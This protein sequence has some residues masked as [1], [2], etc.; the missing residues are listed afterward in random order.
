[1]KKYGR[2]LL[3]ATGGLGIILL[4]LVLLLTVVAPRVISSASVKARIRTEFSRAVGGTLDFDRLGVSLF[5][6]PGVVVYGA[7]LAI[8]EKGSGTVE[9]V[10]ACPQLLPLLRGKV[11]IGK[12]RIEQPV[13]RLDLSAFPPLGDGAA[14]SPSRSL[15]KRAASLFGVL[16]SKVPDL[17]IEVSRGGLEL[18]DNGRAILNIRDLEAKAAFPPRG[19]DVQVSCRSNLWQD[20]SLEGRLDARG[21]KGGG[22]IELSGFQPH[23]L[24]DRL[25]SKAGITCSESSVSLRADIRTEGL[26]RFHGEIKASIPRMILSRNKEESVFKAVNAGATFS[27]EGDKASVSLDQL[28]LDEP[29]LSM[30]GAF[31][32]DRSAS[33]VRL[34]LEARDMDVGAVRHAALCL[35]GESRVVRDIFDYVRGGVIPVITFRSRAPT[36]HGLGVDEAFRIDGVIRDGKIHIRGPGL[37]PDQ[38]SGKAVIEKGILEGEDL[39]ARLGNSRAHDGR[40]RVGLKKGDTAPF[41]LEIMVDAD[42]AEVRP[43]LMRV[44]KPGTFVRELALVDSLQGCAQGKLTLGEDLHAMVAKVDVSQCR[45]SAE[46]RRIPLPVRIDAGEV[47]YDPDSITCRNLSGSLGESSFSG[48]AVRVGFGNDPRIRIESGRFHLLMDEI[49]PWL[50]SYESLRKDLELFRDVKGRIDLTA[51]RLDGPVLRAAEWDF[52]TEAAVQ[53]LTVATRLCPEPV[54]IASGRLKADPKE[55]AFNDVKARLLD[56]PVV[57]SGV[58]YGY[59]KGLGK[60]ETTLEGTIGSKSFDW[61]ADIIHLPDGLKVRTPVPLSQARLVWNRQGNTSFRGDLMFPGGTKGSIDLVQDPHS[62]LLK[63]LSIRDEQSRATLAVTR[64]GDVLGLKFTGNLTA[65]TMDKVFLAN[66]APDLSMKGDFL[67]NIRLD[68]P[69]F[70]EAYGHL[71]ARDFTIP[72]SWMAPIRIDSLS[73]DA[74][75]HGIRV[76]P[77]RFTLEQSRLSLKGE[78][79][80]APQGIHVD[81]DLASA[82]IVWDTIERVIDRAKPEE[83]TGEEAFSSWPRMEGTVRCRTESFTY[84]AFTWAPLCASVTFTP[85]TLSVAVTEADL[86]GI[87]TLGAL[88]RH[89]D[90]IHVDLQLIAKDRDLAPALPCLSDT[91]RQVTGRFDLTGTIKGEGKADAF[92][93]A[94][95]GHMEL[96]ARDGNILKDPL[97]AKV[98][99][100]LNVTEILRGKVPDLS[101][102]E[103]PYDSFT[104]TG[105]LQEGKLVLSEI[106]LSG[107]TVGIVGD[108]TLDLADTMVDMKLVVAPLRTVDFIVEKTPVVK[109]IMG[110]KV[111]TVPV[112][113][114]GDWAD[115][116]VS[117][118][119]ASA[120]GT[121]LLGIMKNTLMLPVDLMQ[122]V[123][124]KNGKNNKK[125]P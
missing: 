24:A 65:E 31:S 34:D 60:A 72:Y 45:M 6:R 26:Q 118:L 96:A 13:F 19:L 121:R 25:L 36:I 54:S 42:I 106:A 116:H 18:V 88:T 84:E 113:V 108:G 77:S 66:M 80:F 52:E 75:E 22:R 79:R 99:S 68:K 111:V 120:V 82:G 9:S 104:A 107:P 20:L 91:K 64:T 38:V 39:E 49:Y 95:H 103:L 87:S 73:L 56:A 67:L 51:L 117:V 27:F 89:G 93:R 35:G 110:G 5:P 57:A 71:E 53:G 55:L 8:P 119:S 62:L 43:I 98:F 63:A 83:G 4:A 59:L 61:I 12:V 33:D 105:D 44:V 14:S 122:P 74:E 114:K 41:H 85:K 37:D 81:M 48:L 10:K 102:N 76:D 30:A 15:E 40:L 58:L 70:S 1:M 115:P 23:L 90:S 7:A 11:R 100:V 86:C 125:S 69:A 28:K 17:E 21:L 50:M 124:T 32:M 29:R 92:V 47:V 109:N 78:L 97:L 3:W 112:R 94:L 16:A 101:G 123:I 46:Y 2:T